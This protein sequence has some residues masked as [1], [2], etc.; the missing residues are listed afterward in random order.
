MRSRERKKEREKIYLC[1][2][3]GLSII[4]DTKIFYLRRIKYQI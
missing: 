4:S 3:G 2:G 1:G